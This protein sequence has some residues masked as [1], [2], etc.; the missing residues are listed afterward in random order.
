M[1]KLDSFKIGGEPALVAV[2]W[3][4]NI[5]ELGAKA[6]EE[7]ADILELR[8]DKFR[9]LNQS[10]LLESIGEIK[11]LGL[12]LIATVRRIDEGGEREIKEEER[13]RLLQSIFPYV[14]AIDIELRSSSIINEIVSRGQE[15]EKTIIVSYHNLKETTTE[16]ELHK[17]AEKAKATGADIVKIAAFAR[18]ADDIA[19]LMNFTYHSSIKPIASISMGVIGTISRII[20]PLFGSCFGYAYLHQSAASG[21]L[22]VSKLR[23]EWRKYK[24][25]YRP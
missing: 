18:E 10:L 23:S 12:P 4:E 2:I 6:K 17:I 22:S 25:S 11:K 16:K 7:G 1:S 19:R 13:L 5:G 21:Q 14:D 20:A 15:L 24:I 3:G 9:Q 8:L